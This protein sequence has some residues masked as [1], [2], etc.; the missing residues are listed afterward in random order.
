MLILQIC[1]IMYKDAKDEGNCFIIWEV[2][3]TDEIRDSRFVF[4]LNAVTL[5]LVLI[6]ALAKLS[7]LPFIYKLQHSF[8]LPSRGSDFFLENCR[9]RFLMKQSLPALLKKKVEISSRTLILLIKPQSVHNGS[10]SWGAWGHFLPRA[11]NNNNFQEK[12]SED[13][14]K[15]SPLVIKFSSWWSYLIW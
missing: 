5:S 8:S 11:I 14:A 1:K 7:L 4:M 10:A 12:S 6:G 9:R 13:K 15:I 3:N 2:E